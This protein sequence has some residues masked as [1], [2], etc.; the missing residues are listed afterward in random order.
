MML[1]YVNFED[2]R[3]H[4]EMKGSS[5]IAKSMFLGMLVFLLVVLVCPTH[6][7]QSSEPEV[8]KWPQL[9][10]LLN[11][12]SPDTVY[13]INFWATWCKPCVAE[14]PYFDSLA[15]IHSSTHL[16]VYLVSLDFRKQLT[17]RLL[18]FIEKN[19]I[20]ATVLL[21]D[22]PDYNSWVGKVS[23]KW[24]GSI[25]ATVILSGKKRHSKFYE[26]EFTFNELEKLVKPL[27]Q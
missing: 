3:E 1:Q 24:T 6:A 10:Q 18:P 27:M 21:L 19:N 23:K 25:P 26:R 4:Q 20:R 22:E 15:V 12:P 7:Q 14:L 9:E 8:I 2:N 16:K 17:S 11:N 5:R 13:V